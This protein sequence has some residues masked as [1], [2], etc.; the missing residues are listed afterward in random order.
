MARAEKPQTV[1]SPQSMDLRMVKMELGVTESVKALSMQ[2]RRPKF[3]PPEPQH[4]VACIC[5]PSS[6]ARWGIGTGDSRRL[7]D[8]LACL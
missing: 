8:Q 4:V 3:G 6:M 5:N 7:V 2:A 1:H